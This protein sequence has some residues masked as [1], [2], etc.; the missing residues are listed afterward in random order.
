MYRNKGPFTLEETEII[1]KWLP[2]GHKVI[3]I[4][5]CD[6]YEDLQHQKLRNIEPENEPIEN[7][8]LTSNG[9]LN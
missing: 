3:K 5:W 4:I 8:N 1:I 7:F 6:P 9:N 2:K